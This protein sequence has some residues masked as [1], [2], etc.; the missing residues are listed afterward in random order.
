MTAAL[1]AS[2]L[3][4]CLPLSAALLFRFYGASALEFYQNYPLLP[5]ACSFLPLAVLKWRKPLIGRFGKIGFSILFELSLT[6]LLLGFAPEFEKLFARQW[7][8]SIPLTLGAAAAGFMTQ[9]LLLPQTVKIFFY[10]LVGFTALAD[11][12][13]TFACGMHSGLVLS[14]GV[15]LLFVFLQFSQARILQG[16]LAQRTFTES[17]LKRLILNYALIFSINL[18]GILLTTHPM[19]ICLAFVFDNLA[20]ETQSGL[21][22]RTV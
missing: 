21:R 18:V 10:W 7:L 5:M 12:L 11:L 9:K 20:A 4:F 14:I 6:V 3:M 13:L 16:R 8:W 22:R 19:K 17:V 1:L 2:L 15:S